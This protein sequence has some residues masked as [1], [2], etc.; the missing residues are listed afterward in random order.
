MDVSRGSVA[1]SVGIRPGDRILS[2]GNKRLFNIGELMALEMES[3]GSA[4][5]AVVMVERD[6]QQLQFVVPG[7]AL[8]VRTPNHVVDVSDRL[9]RALPRPADAR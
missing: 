3:S 8:G 4:S 7:G 6:G 9:R 5:N 1:D 2:Y